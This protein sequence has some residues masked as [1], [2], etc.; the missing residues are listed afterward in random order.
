[1]LRCHVTGNSATGLLYQVLS[2]RDIDLR[3]IKFSN[4]SLRG[5]KM[6]LSKLLLSLSLLKMYLIIQ[7]KTVILLIKAHQLSKN[8]NTNGR[9][10]SDSLTLGHL[11]YIYHFV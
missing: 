11:T 6:T 9:C 5:R 7:V 8:K 4:Q 10:L 2:R 3:Y 1:M